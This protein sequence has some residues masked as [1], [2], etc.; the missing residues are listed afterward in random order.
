VDRTL[1]Y[2]IT[3]ATIFQLFTP[4]T[5]TVSAVSGLNGAALLAKP[6]KIYIRS[7]HW[8]PRGAI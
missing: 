7:L 1:L 6:N 4:A 5:K 3:E 8:L 2:L